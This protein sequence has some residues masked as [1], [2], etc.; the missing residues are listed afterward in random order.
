MKPMTTADVREIASQ[1]ADAARRLG[2]QDARIRVNRER[3]VYLKSSAGELEQIEES[4]ELS[5]SAALFVD[6]RFSTH[7]TSD[8]RPEG[9]EAFLKNAVAMTRYLVPEP[10]R[11]LPPPELYKG[12]EEKELRLNDAAYDTVDTDTRKK[13]ITELNDAVAGK[14][15][16]LNLVEA[17]CY[18]SVREGALV[19]TNG[20]TGF[21]RGTR[22]SVG[23]DITAQDPEGRRVQYGEE[24][25][26]RFRVDLPG[27]SQLAGGVLDRTLKS[28][29]AKPLKTQRLPM[30]V[31]NRVAGRLLGRLVAPMSASLVQQRQ[32]FLEGKKG[33]RF[34]SE[35]LTLV[36]DP[37][38]P[39]ALGSTLFDGEGMPARRRVMIQNGTLQDYWID[40][41]YG[42]KLGWAPTSAGP[43]NLVIEPGKEDL[44]GLM[45]QAGKGILVT[46][47]LGGNSNSTTGD[48]SMGINGFYFE[49]G[50]IAQPVQEMNIAGNHLEFWKQL[51]AVGNDPYLDSTMR[52]PSML[53]DG[54]MF[55]GV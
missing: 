46:G 31:E 22:F 10:A 35:V 5:L 55:S 43:S 34:A 54:V 42:N 24:A 4:S 14:S 11:T 52:F 41:Y 18:D 32:S 39:T 12:Y 6:G 48:F 20:F 27:T 40:V 17:Y 44:D 49:N 37:H 23:V 21:Q 45:R 19:N 8:L 28:L 25:A 51:V 30:I 50:K 3:Y 47:F 16:A 36:D 9:L 13:V 1:A 33:Q 29:G 2:A 7:T 38:L 26:R 15:P 53:I